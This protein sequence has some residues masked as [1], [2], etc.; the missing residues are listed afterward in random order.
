MITYSGLNGYEGSSHIVVVDDKPVMDFNNRNT[1]GLKGKALAET[2]AENL[3]IRY[4]SE[5]FKIECSTPGMVTPEEMVEAALKERR[6]SVLDLGMPDKIIDYA[7]LYQGAGR[8]IKEL[9]DLG[10]DHQMEDLQVML[11][12]AI[13]HE[14]WVHLRRKGGIGFDEALPDEL[15]NALCGRLL[16][17]D[18]E[19][20]PEK[21][22]TCDGCR[23]DL[24]K[25]KQ[26][27][28]ESGRICWAYAQ[29]RSQA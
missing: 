27:P 15:W 8:M 18:E 14:Y 2:L 17:G 7:R 13:S 19:D 25:V 23:V 1:M 12:D 11:E 22:S 21:D 29:R 26:C 16:E 4:R 3:A 6:K 10:I 5:V 24:S 20:A 28:N 9:N